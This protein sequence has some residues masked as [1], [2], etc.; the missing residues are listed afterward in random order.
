[1]DMLSFYNGILKL[2]DI[3]ADSDDMLSINT[4]GTSRNSIWTI[5]GKR[6]VLPS[7]KQLNNPD[8]SNRYAFHPLV[9]SQIGAESI[10]MD[11]FRR[12]INS[13]L[14]LRAT[15]LFVSMANLCRSDRSQERTNLGAAYNELFHAMNTADDRFYEN[16][17]KLI[18]K[19]VNIV[20][21]YVRRGMTVN[22]NSMRV[23]SETYFPLL[24]SIKE[25]KDRVVEGVKFRIDDIALLQRMYEFVFPGSTK[26]QEYR[27]G[28]DSPAVPTVLAQVSNTVNLYKIFNHFFTTYDALEGKSLVVDLSDADKWLGDISGPIAEATAIGMLDG[29]L[30]KQKKNA[31]TPAIPVGQPAPA[32]P[33]PQPAAAVSVQALQQSQPTPQSHPVIGSEPPKATPVTPVQKIGSPAPAGASGINPATTGYYANR[34]VAQSV[35]QPPQQP[36]PVLINT[37]AGIAA[38][39]PI[40]MNEARELAIKQ[41]QAQQ[42]A[43]QAQQQNQMKL[44]QAQQLGYQVT[45]SPTGPLVMVSDGKGGVAYTPIA[46]WEPP[47]PVAGGPAV[48][49]G[50]TPGVAAMPA[51]PAMPGV[52]TMP[53]VPAVPAVP[54]QPV[55]PG[56]TVS[57]DQ[58]MASNPA[59]AAVY[60]Q[61]Y[62]QQLQAQQVQQQIQQLQQMAAMGYNVEG[63]MPSIVN[64][65]QVQQAYVPTHARV[66]S[67]LPQGMIT[68]IGGI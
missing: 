4:A 58:W 36:A 12:C 60:N 55:T 18:D 2:G 41:Q 9:E 22:G 47:A 67:M 28:S 8:W 49:P 24:E 48:V 34:S 25:S 50:V 29:N 13:S 54:A 19:N 43:I 44:F 40:S 57:I 56:G 15:Y 39:N 1:M 65:Q 37:G 7:P 27:A 6:L 66:A 64:P 45:Q 61:N 3:V 14:N 10:I 11:R 5:T 68:P 20:H 17:I 23:G 26:G 31:S 51:M 16:L 30:P 21:T 35:Q 38:V 33:V 42:A 63:M 62:M 59:M 53:G 32:A 46:Q 52:P